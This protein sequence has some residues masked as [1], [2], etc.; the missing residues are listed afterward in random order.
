MPLKLPIVSPALEVAWL[1]D[2]VT[3]II[4][5]LSAKFGTA[6]HN[7]A[8]VSIQGQPTAVMTD[9]YQLAL[10][11]G[12]GLIPVLTSRSAYV[13]DATLDHTA[14]AVAVKII[15][16]IEGSVNNNAMKEMMS[17]SVQGI[18]LPQVGGTLPS[19]NSGD[20]KVGNY[21][22]A[23]ASILAPGVGPGAGF[24]GT[25]P[26][27]G[28]VALTDLPV[29][30]P[31]LINSYGTDG[32]GTYAFPQPSQSLSLGGQSGLTGSSTALPSVLKEPGV[33]PGTPLSEAS[34]QASGDIRF[35]L[36]GLLKNIF[37]L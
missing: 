36:N 17:R 7:Y 21:P 8:I 34:T 24:T 26:N 23:V 9:L 11:I 14:K 37:G 32:R 2:S 33:P 22:Y 15:Y 35:K 10:G 12:T 25:P 16:L 27:I 3:G 30:N 28:S 20:I 5:K 31:R 19:I 13:I 4:D 18:P 29:D 6:G 1:I